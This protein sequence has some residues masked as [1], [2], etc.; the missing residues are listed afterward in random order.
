MSSHLERH[1]A[2]PGGHERLGTAAFYR[3]REHKGRNV[4]E[5]PSKEDS[6]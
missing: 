5:I 3:E 2:W 6:R 1:R 4:L